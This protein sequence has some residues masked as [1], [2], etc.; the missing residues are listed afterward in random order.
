MSQAIGMR[1]VRDVPVVH[2]VFFVALRDAIAGEVCQRYLGQDGHLRQCCN[3]YGTSELSEKREKLWP[4]QVEDTKRQCVSGSAVQHQPPAKGQIPDLQHNNRII[5]PTRPP[6]ESSIGR[7]KSRRSEGTLK[8]LENTK[9]WLRMAKE[10]ISIFVRPPVGHLGVERR[11]RTAAGM[12]SWRTE[13]S[14]WT[15]LFFGFFFSF[16]SIFFFF[17]PFFPFFLVITLLTG[18]STGKFIA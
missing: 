9:C 17:F 5:G 15:R 11:R 7:R 3:L 14:L 18:N 16:F 2:V 13:E 8:S 12:G 4:A 10:R 6:Y 1:V